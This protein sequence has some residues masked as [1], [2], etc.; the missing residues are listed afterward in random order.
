MNLV[1]KLPFSLSLA[2]CLMMGACSKEDI[3]APQPQTEKVSTTANLKAN[4]IPVIPPTDGP[5]GLGV[6]ANGWF[7]FVNYKPDDLHEHAA[8]TSTLTHA[9]GHPAMPWLKPLSEPVPKAGNFLTFIRHQNVL[10]AGVQGHSQVRT[11]IKNL[12]PGKKYSISLYGAS[13]IGTVNGL[14]TQYADAIYI[15]TAGTN[16]GYASISLTGLKAQWKHRILTFQA[17]A[18]TAYFLFG[19]LGTN[20]NPPKHYFY[21]HLFVDKDS[22]KEI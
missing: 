2:C 22:L 4:A 11:I 8:G 13:S 17:T 20:N 7:K 15:L 18:T 19:C 12:K 16:V 5:A 1:Q 10:G 21:G 14:T 3:Q 6:Y 9:W